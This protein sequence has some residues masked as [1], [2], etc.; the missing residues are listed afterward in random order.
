MAD[1][2]HGVGE[3]LPGWEAIDLIKLQATV[4]G[5][6]SAAIE[7]GSGRRK[8]RHFAQVR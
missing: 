4:E 5:Q 3:D 8:S 6:L 2:Y 1:V 7:K